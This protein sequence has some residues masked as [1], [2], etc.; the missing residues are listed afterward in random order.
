MKPRPEWG[1][2][3]WLAWQEQLHPRGIDLGLERVQRVAA[4]LGLPGTGVRTLTVAGTNGKGSSA[5]LAALIYRSAGYRVGL[6]TSP[7][8]LRYN[9]RI[10]ID[11]APVA[12]DALCRAFGQIE[13]V[14]GDESLTYFEYGTLAAL[15]LFQQARVDVQVLEV[16]LGG[17]LD[18][19]NIVDPDCAVITNIGLDHTDWLGPDRESIGAEKAGIL[20]P[21]RPAICVEADPPRSVV[22]A[23]ADRKALMQVFSRDF[24]YEAS[25]TGWRWWGR[26][27][28]IAELPMPG[29]SG[30]AQLRNAAGVIAAVES[31][32]AQ[33]PVPDA[34]IRAA[35]PALSLPGRF[36]RRKQFILDVAHNVEAAAVLVENLKAESIAGRI[37]LV[38]GML[39]DKPVESF[40]GM[41]APLVGTTRFASLPPPRGLSAQELSARASTAGL[42]G[43][44]HASVAEA[45]A[46]ARA[47]AGS[48]DRILVTGSFL[49][50]AAASQHR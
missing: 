10:W 47:S 13:L 45:I 35:L 33:L 9:E 17:R 8:L 19:V 18:A 28:G 41:L 40:C 43:G 44:C 42:Q 31:L 36:E 46:A 3:Q 38:L 20:R 14:R 26:D 15:W 11:G 5:T 7:H 25:A 30:V 29:L 32:Q 1:L 50:V 6:Y 16:G 4:R 48:E 24:G 2:A 22:A 23:A 49:T 12:D 34:A 37:H 21:G 39:R 27:R